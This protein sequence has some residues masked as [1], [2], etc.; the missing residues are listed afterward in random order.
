MSTKGRSV[1][2]YIP[3]HRNYLVIYI[4][5]IKTRLSYHSKTRLD[6]L[7][8]KRQLDENDSDDSKVVQPTQKKRKKIP[9]LNKIL[10]EFRPIT[11][12]SFKPFK[13]KAQQ[14]ATAILPP[15]FLPSSEL[16]DYFTLF[17][18]PTLLQ[19]ITTNTNRYTDL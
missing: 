6:T 19:I 1:L 10:N 18:T 9:T 5:S 17:F 16:Y 4:A 14:S 3:L 2:I 15:D 13:C 7:K 8:I 11:S 12:V